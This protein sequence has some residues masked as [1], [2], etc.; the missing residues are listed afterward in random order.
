MYT[1]CSVH[2]A[3][4]ERFIKSKLLI[5]LP[6]RYGGSFRGKKK[7]GSA[8]F[9]GAGKVAGLSLNVEFLYC[10]SCI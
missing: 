7:S 9:K 10:R 4:L 6:Y 3:F 5:L 1:E 2:R 8:L